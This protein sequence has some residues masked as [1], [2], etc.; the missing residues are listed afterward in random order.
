MHTNYVLYNIVPFG[1]LVLLVYIFIDVFLDYFRKEI[2]P[3]QRRVT[4]Y[5][6]LFY[7]LC[8]L[9]IKVGG[10]TLLPLNP[11][12][13]SRSFITANDWFGI[14]DGIHFSMYLWSYSAIVY[15]F[16]LLLPLGIFL[17]VLFHFNN[18][19]KAIFIV[20]LCCLGIELLR[21][22]LGSFSLVPRNI[23]SLDGIYLLCNMLGGIVGILIVKIFTQIKVKRK[24]K[25]YNGSFN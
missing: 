5:S 23:G 20:I 10:I 3:N 9:Q 7:L 24:D 21:L 2:K 1:F 13:K 18:R 25:V 14:F 16:L 12:D 11:A 4:L 17:F 8:L 22:L 15:N 6:F 19:N